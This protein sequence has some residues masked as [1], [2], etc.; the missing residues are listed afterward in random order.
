MYVVLIITK[1]NWAVT[2]NF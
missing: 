2:T 1:D